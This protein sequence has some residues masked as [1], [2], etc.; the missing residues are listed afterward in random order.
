M[1]VYSP[2]SYHLRCSLEL[3][4]C[5]SCDSDYRGLKKRIKA[6]RREQGRSVDDSSESD[7]DP[8][9]R[10]SGASAR[11]RND[12]EQIDDEDHEA[13]DESNVHRGSHGQQTAVDSRDG[14]IELKELTSGHSKV[15]TAWFFTLPP[16]NVFSRQR[17]PHLLTHLPSRPL[18][19]WAGA[20]SLLCRRQRLTHHH[21]PRAIRVH[22][23]VCADV[24][25]DD[26]IIFPANSTF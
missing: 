23:M 7:P 24:P 4:Y 13:D 21:F 2:L 8:L 20:L 19:A 14:E 10:G 18:P 3:A 5:W 15:D 11:H 26:V 6:I 9:L 16:L 22:G 12:G 17:P 25:L 1:Y